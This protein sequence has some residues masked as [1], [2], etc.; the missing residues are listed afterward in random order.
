MKCQKRHEGLWMLA[1]LLAL[2]ALGGPGSLRAAG[3]GAAVNKDVADWL[4]ELK[5]PP[6]A[7][8]TAEKSEAAPAGKAK[9]SAAAPAAP[10]GLEG[11]YGDAKRISVDFYKVDL[12]NV[13]RLL[14]QISGKNIV[15]DESVRGTL[16]LALQDVP[17]TFV[18]DVIKNLKNLGSEERFNTIMIFPR[19]KAL[20][21]TT[22]EA[23]GASGQVMVRSP[24][25]QAV[26]KK[27]TAKV[28]AKAPERQL[29]IKRT[30]Q[31]G[32]SSAD[33]LE[34]QKY[35]GQ[36]KQAERRGEFSRAVRF[37]D[38]AL[39]KWPT[40]VT[41][42]KKL[43]AICLGRLGDNVGALRYAR[44]ALKA[45]PVD[46]GAAVY[47]A[48]ALSRL[49]KAA[50]ARVY[51][52]KALLTRSPSPFALY[53]YAVFSEQQGS[54][55]AALRLI[56][57]YEAIAGVTGETLLMKA[58]LLAR[59]GKTRRAIQE[60]EAF[61][62]AGARQPEK[63][64]RYAEAEL[65]RLK[66]EEAARRE[67]EAVEAAPVPPPVAPPEVIPVP[68]GPPEA[69]PPAE[70]VPEV[71]ELLD[72]VLESGEAAGGPANDTGGPTP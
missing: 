56:E 64:R 47:A 29:E 54:Y 72:Q 50:E 11:L 45:S 35:I 33:L 65:A 41:L 18:L 60:Y 21:W 8:A 22:D 46:T 25:I 68:E 44:L 3:T 58:R 66:A 23:T 4:A 34:A 6:A 71:R 40:N 16:T 38:K 59:L 51:Y 15:V 39:Q 17:W 37:Y 52:E 32:I 12:H 10:F 5:Q 9:A 13:F 53:N 69:P 62:K 49:G 30:L 70:S 63:M 24:V 2:L 43:A 27:P 14:G 57:R 61:L 31:A 28:E 20:N 1:G 26:P 36:G 67:R 48:L 55:R 19:G 7:N 42:A